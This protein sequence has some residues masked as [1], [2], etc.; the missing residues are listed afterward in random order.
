M[1]AARKHPRLK[2]YDYAQPG[3]YFITVCTKDKKCILGRVVGRG[4]LTPPGILLTPTGKTV[5]RYTRTIADT[6]QNITLDRYVIMPNHVHLLLTIHAAGGGVGS[7]RPTI[8]Q[9]IK[10][11]KHLITRD[12]G[13]SIWQASFYDHV[14]RDEV[15]YQEIWQYIDANPARWLQDRFYSE[16]DNP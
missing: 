11:W 3:S 7:P 12:A 4:D 8:A 14:V 2:E 16:E 15:A 6:Y 9:I 13:E 10:A 5:L 1:K